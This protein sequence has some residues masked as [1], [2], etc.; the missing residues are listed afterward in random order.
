MN[1]PKRIPGLLLALEDYERQTGFTFDEL[2][3]SLKAFPRPDVTRRHRLSTAEKSIVWE[4]TGGRCIYCGAPLNPF[5][6]LNIDHRIPLS[7]GGADSLDNMVPACQSCNLS[8]GNRLPEV[9]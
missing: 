6:D 7:C 9:A 3:A 5:R 2:L 8:K 1:V 4:K